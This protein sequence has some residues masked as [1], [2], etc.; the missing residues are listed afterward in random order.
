MELRTFR[1]ASMHEALALVRRELGPDA[2]VLQTREVRLR[3]FFG[4]LPG[5]KQIEIDGLAGR[6]RPQLAA[7]RG[8]CRKLCAPERF[9]RLYPIAAGHAGKPAPFAQTAA[10]G[11]TGGAR[12]T[13]RFAGDGEGTGPPLPVGRVRRFARR[14]VPTL[15]EIAR[16]RRWRGTRPR[17]RRTAERERGATFP[18]PSLQRGLRG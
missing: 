6:E 2:A 1:A 5:V 18:T 7:G 9:P 15:H 13:R 14:T 12:A 10:G 8:A 17:T 16:R 3:R 4:C 11:R